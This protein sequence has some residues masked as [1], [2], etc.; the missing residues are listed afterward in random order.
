MEGTLYIVATPIGN[1]ADISVRAIDVLKGVAIIYC[2]DTRRARILCAHYDITTPLKSCHSYNERRVAPYMCRLLKEGAS[3]AYI[4][5]AGTPTIS[6]PGRILAST[7]QERG[8]RVVPIPGASAIHALLSASG[9]L[10]HPYLFYGFLPRGATRAARSVR[11]L[12]DAGYP[13]VLFESPHRMLALCELLSTVAPQR[14]IVIGRELTKKFEEIRK[15]SAEEHYDYFKQK[16]LLGEFIILV[17][18]REIR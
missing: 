4:S 3:C 7:A 17:T 5:D 13:F 11:T 8:F 1:L 16:K 14:M 18:K 9:E 12:L 2:E 6:D 10:A 15:G